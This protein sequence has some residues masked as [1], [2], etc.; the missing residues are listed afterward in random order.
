MLKYGKPRVGCRFKSEAGRDGVKI[1]GVVEHH[2]QIS[3]MRLTEYVAVDCV[4]RR[5]LWGS[6]KSY[7]SLSNTGT[8]PL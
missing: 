4:V 1:K 8:A 3:S 5:N 7:S 2:A 6:K